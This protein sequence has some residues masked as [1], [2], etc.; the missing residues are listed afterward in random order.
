MRKSA[1]HDSQPRDLLS[2]TDPQDMRPA[3]GSGRD[4]LGSTS[5][6]SP[7]HGGALEV[8]LAFLRLGLT[9]F[10]GPAAHI[11]Y[12]REAFVLRRR[13]L[14]ET[15]FAALIALCQFL[16]GP[17]SSQAG[18]AIGVQRT[19]GIGGGVAAFLGFTAPSAIIMTALASG[20]SALQGPLAA[21][22]LHGL[23]LTA[24]AVVAHAV[25]GMARLL[26]P[27]R[28]RATIALVALAIVTPGG[29]AAQLLAIGA[30][31]LLGLAVCRD[32]AANGAPATARGPVSRRAGTAAL[33]MF[34]GLFLLLPMAAS[35]WGGGFSLFSAFYRTGSLVFG[36]GHVVLPLLQAEVAAPAG[37]PPDAFLTGYALA[38]AMPGPMF[39]FAAW[40]GALM[41]T[42]PTGAL[43]A[44][45]AVLAIFL[46]G[47]LLVYG[48][49]PFWARLRANPRAAAAMAGANAA[50]VGI[51]GAAL[52]QPLWTSAVFTPRDFV[53]AVAGFL[54]LA[55]WKAPPWSVALAGAGAGAL[56]AM[57]P[58]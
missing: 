31:G 58:G 52:Y 39:A 53:L 21:G 55:V 25:W 51:L 1:P 11:G 30:G 7:E 44:A 4:D 6:L 43:G 34:A 36:G 38:Q 2:R 49:L 23:K 35:L 9:A 12:F 27:D 48:T 24:V 3:N 33:A 40:L 42:P 19:G 41:P 37:I 10:G 17:G 47:Q 56:L 18:F 14:S 50:V 26:T 20:A 28:A 8:F 54:L 57:L 15:D 45:L 46:P 13:W 5:G 32:A 16:P 29:V 22:M